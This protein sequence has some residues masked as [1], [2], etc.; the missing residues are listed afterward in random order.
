MR[1][2]GA[3][4]R[5]TSDKLRILISGKMAALKTE[6]ELEEKDDEVLDNENENVEGV[7]NPEAAKKKKKKK[8]KKAGK[9]SWSS[10]GT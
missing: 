4:F 9:I 3:H 8:K 6:V 5:V 1:T 7:N 2:S 10:S